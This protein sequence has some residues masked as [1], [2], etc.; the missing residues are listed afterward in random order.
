MGDFVIDSIQ[1]E[2]QKTML[3]PTLI[4]ILI[5]F[6]SNGRCN[7]TDFV[8]IDEITNET[9]A[10]TE[11]SIT[12]DQVFEGIFSNVIFVIGFKLLCSIEWKIMCKN[13]II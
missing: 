8:N 10:T 5:Y 6:I 3:K 11:F 2:F 1:R 4:L 7:F 12:N 13:K 9:T